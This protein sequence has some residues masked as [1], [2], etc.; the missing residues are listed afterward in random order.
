[1]QVQVK[2]ERPPF[3][4]FV[5]REVENRAESIVQGKYVARSVDYAL[6]TPQGSRDSVEREVDVWFVYLS[7]QAKQGRIDPRWVDGWK[8]AYE[9]WKKGE[10]IPLN[11]T[12]IRTWPVVTP[13]QV[14]LLVSLHIL[15]VEDLAGANDETLGRIGMGSAELKKR[16]QDYLKEANG[17]GKLVQEVS[18]LRLEVA[19]LKARCEGLLAVNSDL[20]Q[21]LAAAGLK[22]PERPQPR[23]TA[24]VS[25]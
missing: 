15:T 18:A 11:G 10:E 19:D 12:P 1:M 22:P 20:Q 9:Q 13:A 8:Y 16:A 3:V 7:E 17:P 23:E 25:L 24:E 6:I 5:R 4:Q 14:K 2:E 21:Q